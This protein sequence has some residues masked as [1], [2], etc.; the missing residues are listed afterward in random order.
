MTQLN[1]ML[2]AGWPVPGD[3]HHCTDGDQRFLVVLD[4]DPPTAP[5][6]VG[7]V[8]ALILTPA[9]RVSAVAEVVTLAIVQ[10]REEWAPLDVERP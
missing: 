4:F 5:G 2:A 3:L 7:I 9:N 6:E 1:D 8:E 10:L